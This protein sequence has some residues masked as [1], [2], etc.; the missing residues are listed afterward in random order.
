MLAALDLAFKLA[1]ANKVTV[2]PEQLAIRTRLR[3][4]LVSQANELRESNEINPPGI[5]D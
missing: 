3:K 2:T 5:P 4:Q 1:E